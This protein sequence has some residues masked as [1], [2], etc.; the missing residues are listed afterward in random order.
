[1]TPSQLIAYL[2]AIAVGELDSIRVKIAEARRACVELEQ[3]ELVRS[4]DEATS[5]L[6]RA[7][8]PLYRKRLQSVVARLGHMR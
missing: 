6:D 1:M 2:N 8:L 4:L 7:D 3:D 5:A